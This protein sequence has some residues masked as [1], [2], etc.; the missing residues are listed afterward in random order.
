MYAERMKYIRQNIFGCSQ[1]EFAKITGASQ[2]RVCR[3]ELGETE[4]SHS[5]LAAIRAEASLRG[6]N[7]DDRYFFEV[8]DD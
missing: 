6:I 5:Q 4:A 1:A 2:T 7:W 3:W 8:V